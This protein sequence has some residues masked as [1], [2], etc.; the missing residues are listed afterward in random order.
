MSYRSF[1]VPEAN[2]LL[3]HLREV[4][5]ELRETREEAAGHHEKLQLL[6]ALWGEGLLDEDNPDHREFRGRRKAIGD[7]ARSIRATVE[8]EIR[9]RGI[10]FP[11]GGLE[12]GLIDFPSSFD[13]RWVYLCWRL[14]EPK[15]LY[16]HELDGG[17]RGRRKITADQVRRMGREDDPAELDDSELD[18]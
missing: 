13:G 17:F 8:S 15:V 7:L 4:L 2:A 18:V 3:P 1:T 9:A 11:A 6:D 10:R 14:G 12:Y 5:Q 16:W